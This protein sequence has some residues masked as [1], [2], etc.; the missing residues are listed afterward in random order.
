MKRAWILLKSDGGWTDAEISA[1][2]DS[3]LRT[4]AEIRERFCD[5]SRQG[6][7]IDAPRSG[8][9]QTFTVKQRQQVAALACTDPPEGRSRAGLRS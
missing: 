4:V 8:K 1:E 5:R 7:V 9:P 2:F 3:G 6:T